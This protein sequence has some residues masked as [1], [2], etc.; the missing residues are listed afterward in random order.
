MQIKY[1]TQRTQE[2]YIHTLATIFGCQK[3]VLSAM[4]KKLGVTFMKLL[5]TIFIYVHSKL[6]S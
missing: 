3:A 1:S 5:Y 6:I 2:L 4:L